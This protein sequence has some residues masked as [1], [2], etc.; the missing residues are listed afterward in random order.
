M[1]KSKWTN[2]EKSIVLDVMEF[3]P[4]KKLKTSSSHEQLKIDWKSM[5]SNILSKEELSS[6]FFPAHIE[7][8]IKLRN[9]I[10]GVN[11]IEVIE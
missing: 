6:Q 3:H 4:L 8:P 7:S 10:N 2:E 1:T 9:C 5:H 11:A